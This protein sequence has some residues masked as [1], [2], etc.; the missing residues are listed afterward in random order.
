MVVMA[1]IYIYTRLGAIT[2]DYEQLVLMREASEVWEV[3]E[4]VE[5]QPRVLCSCVTARPG[6]H[7][8]EA[9]VRM[10]IPCAFMGSKS[11]S[12]QKRSKVRI[13]NI[14]VAS[15]MGRPWGRRYIQFSDGSLQSRMTL[16][17]AV[18]D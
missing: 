7:A 9:V 12:C 13:R 18:C 5:V 14:N 1:I 4:A 6:M 16:R 11:A 15:P 8:R 3:P 10:L 17:V 2:S